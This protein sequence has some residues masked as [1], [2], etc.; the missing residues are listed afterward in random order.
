MSNIHGLEF[1]GNLHDPLSIHS[2][3]HGKDLMV[4]HLTS[5]IRLGLI[6]HPKRFILDQF[7]CATT[8]YLIRGIIHRFDCEL[9]TNQKEYNELHDKVDVLLSLE[10]QFA[11]PVINWKKRSIFRKNQKKALSYVMYSD[12]HI[13]QWRENYFLEN[14]ISFVL[15]L[16]YAPTNYH[17]KKIPD[18]CLVH[19]PWCVPDQF[20]SN[21]PI[22]CRNQDKICCFG[23]A[24]SDAYELRNWCKSFP[25]VHASSNSGVENKQYTNDEYFNWLYGYDAIIAAG[26]E[27]PQ[28]KL[29]TPKYFEIPAS[30]ALLFA[31]ETDDLDRLGFSH[32]KN[33]VIFHRGNFEELAREYLKHSDQFLEVRNAGRE[34]I[35]GAHS[36]SIR[37][38]QFEDHVARHL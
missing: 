3:T 8:P 33:C 18:N 13:L 23:G 24:K 10:P 21:A 29:T 25:F 30:G 14:E 31:Q 15:A 37:L 17:F 12:P 4:S 26:S 6:M 28:Y 20:I 1:G 38:A 35:L 11:A 16:Y 9:I 7:T 5:K 34:L 2:E 22:I 32:M 19:F 27:A 36:L